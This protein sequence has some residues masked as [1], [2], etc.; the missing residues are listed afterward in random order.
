LLT[1]S[2]ISKEYTQNSRRRVLAVKDVSF[3]VKGGE[4]VSIVGPSGCGKTTLLMCIAG[5]MVPSGGHV[6]LNEKVVTRPPKEIALIFQNYTNS[7]FPWRTVIGNVLFALENKD[8]PKTKKTEIAEKSLM[9]MGLGD[10]SGHYP[11]E[12]SGGMQQRVAIARGLAY[13]SEIIL[14]DEPFAS[15]DA[16][17]RADLEDLLLTVWERHSKTILFV[18]HD[19]DEAVYL[20]SRVIVL[21]RRPSVVLDTIAV[22]LE[23]PRNQ[24]ETKGDKRFIA[25]RNRIYSLIRS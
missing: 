7:L 13:G 10:F 3:Q 15:V 8:I 20:S 16:Q 17:T 12:L 24:L 21:S 25:L 22:D 6:L 11:W 14:M 19:I 23:R 2:N 4:F 18:T 9:S 5:L 1:I